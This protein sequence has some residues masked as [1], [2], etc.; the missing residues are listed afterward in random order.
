M[1]CYRFIDKPSGFCVEWLSQ[2]RV[3]VELQRCALSVAHERRA[4]R[5]CTFFDRNRLALLIAMQF[6]G[7]D[8]PGAGAIQ[9]DTPSPWVLR[10]AR[11]LRT[12]V[13]LPHLRLL[14]QIDPAVLE[15]HMAALR[16]AGRVPS[17][18]QEEALYR[19]PY[20]LK[21]IL[22]Y[23]AAAIAFAYLRSKSLQ[24]LETGSGRTMAEAAEPSV[25]ELIDAMA[26]WR[27][28]FAPDGR[29]YRSLNRTLMNLPPDVP[30]ELVCCLK[31]IRLE[32]P[33]VKSLELLA[34]LLYVQSADNPAHETTANQHFH[35]FH[36][37]RAVDIADAMWRIGSF[38]NRPLRHGSVEDVRFTIRYL[39]DYPEPYHG[40]LTGLVERVIRWHRQ[41]HERKRLEDLA[42]QYG[43]PNRRTVRPPIPL[44]TLPGVT[45][46]HTVGDVVEEGARMKH[47]IATHLPEAIRGRCFL[48]HV[49]YHG[50]RA[51]IEVSAAGDITGAA[52]PHNAKNVAVRWG[53]TQLQAWA[54]GLQPRLVKPTERRPKSRKAGDPS[55]LSL[56]FGG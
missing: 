34:L 40:T 41:A 39:C 55:Q 21:D 28:L 23:R 42:R 11:L 5:R 22:N 1:G 16:V 12:E 9:P 47:C 14:A 48:F 24:A 33:V 53:A 37:A 44:P 56:Q 18:A 38:V 51:S 19:E 32:R 30:P 17:L 8:D 29:T 6:L 35:M 26:H 36:H 43:G 50:E 13:G 52:G 15:V 46:L 31:Q 10:E 49:D 20:I 7:E 25:A 27:D 54:A 3:T 45:F 2:D 4:P